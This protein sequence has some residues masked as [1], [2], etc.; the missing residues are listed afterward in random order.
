MPQPGADSL[1]KALRVLDLFTPRRSDWGTAEVSRE[2]GLPVSTANRILLALA[3]SGYL[4][5][6]AGG[7]YRLGLAAVR[8]GERAAA[9]FDIAALARPAL[10]WLVQTTGETAMFVLP[11][12][13]TGRAVVAE[14]IDSPH[15]LKVTFP[16]QHEVPRD[17]GSIATIFDAFFPN[18]HEPVIDEERLRTTREQG[19]ALSVEETGTGSWGV[20]APFYDQTGQPVGIIALMAPMARLTDETRS[21]AV[22]LVMSASRYLER[23]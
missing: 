2:L 4:A 6:S 19:Y 12:S 18:V 13:R 14:F 23:H 11:D 8:L 10:Q 7:R 5:R 20:S 9:T 21:R 16:V 1:R 22:E 3:E 17:A 15:P